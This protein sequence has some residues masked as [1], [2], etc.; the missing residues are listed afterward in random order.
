MLYVEGTAVDELTMH[1][2]FPATSVIAGLGKGDGKTRERG[3]R[4]LG[5]I[6]ISKGL[7]P[8]DTG[9][10]GTS[11]RL[12]RSWRWGENIDPSYILSLRKE[13]HTKLIFLSPCFS[14]L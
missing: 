2:C 12:Q 1:I 4:P 10:T 5:L 8:V 13:G 11:E 3:T 9:R 7:I 6:A 14:L